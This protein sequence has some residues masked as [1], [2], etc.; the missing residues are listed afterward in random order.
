MMKTEKEGNNWNERGF[1]EEK[2]SN[3]FG[4]E[5]LIKGSF[6]TMMSLRDMCDAIRGRPKNICLRKK[7]SYFLPK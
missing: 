6:M 4:L 7:A 5:N 3:Y 2:S 1:D